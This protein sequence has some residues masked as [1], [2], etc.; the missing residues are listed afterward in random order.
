MSWLIRCLGLLFLCLAQ[1]AKEGKGAKDASPVVHME[2]EPQSKECNVTALDSRLGILEASVNSKANATDVLSKA[3]VHEHFKAFDAA[4]KQR[5]SQEGQVPQVQQVEVKDRGLLE[6]LSRAEVHDRFKLFN[7]S[8]AKDLAAVRDEMAELKKLLEDAMLRKAD[9]N[10]VM[11]KGDV[12][13]RFRLFHE[14]MKTSSGSEQ[15]GGVLAKLQHVENRLEKLDAAVQKNSAYIDSASGAGVSLEE[16]IQQLE[17]AIQIASN[18]SGGFW[19]ILLVLSL[20]FPI[21]LALSSMCLALAVHRHSEARIRELEVQLA[22]H[23][24]DEEYSDTD[25]Q[26][27]DTNGQPRFRS[28]AISGAVGASVGGATGASVGTALGGALGAVAGLVPAFFTFGLSI[29]I[30]AVLGSGVGLTTGTLIGSSTGAVGG[31]T[32]MKWYHSRSERLRS[33]SEADESMDPF[34]TGGKL[35]KDSNAQKF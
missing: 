10:S 18:E 3:E 34:V 1:A 27:V 17:V 15:S 11:S 19:W 4:L 13:E 25:A 32:A 31:V 5:I 2:G 35:L 23:R 29:P 6:T 8:I 12:N 7:A 30:G 24:A 26:S 22:K 21:L 16:K 28:K 33:I 14:A 20:C 9:R